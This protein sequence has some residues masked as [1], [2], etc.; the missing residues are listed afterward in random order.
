MSASRAMADGR[1]ENKSF[2]DLLM[3]GKGSLGEGLGPVELLIFD[4]QVLPAKQLR[5]G[6]E[7]QP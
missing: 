6:L 2:L 3:V 1:S 7:Q 5:E 4:C